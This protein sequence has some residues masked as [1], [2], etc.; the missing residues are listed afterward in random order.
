M[1]I[2]VILA[3]CNGYGI[4]Y[5]GKMC[6]HV[7]ADLKRFARLTTGRGNYKNAF[8]MGR[9]T[10]QSMPYKRP[11]PF[12]DN[13][14]LSSAPEAS[15]DHLFW[16]STIDAILKHCEDKQYDEA[17]VIGGEKLYSEFLDAR[18]PYLPLIHAVHL[19]C[20]DADF[21]CDTFCSPDFVSRAALEK[22]FTLCSETTETERCT[23]LVDGSPATN[24]TVTQYEYMRRT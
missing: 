11:L 14:I 22:H 17:W 9:K 20:I 10:W 7:G 13:L 1:K 24:A 16:F 15:K 6:W 19:T 21:T 18:S 4:G 2:N 5:A 12:R 3:H 8:I 23:N